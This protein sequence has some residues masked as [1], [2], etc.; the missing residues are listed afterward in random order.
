MKRI[1]FSLLLTGLLITSTSCANQNNIS[2][3]KELETVKGFLSDTQTELHEV[4]DIGPL[5]EITIKQGRQKAIIYVTKDGKYIVLGNIFDKDR[6][7]ITQERFAEISKVDFSAL[8]LQD[9]ITIT[10]GNG[11]KKIVMLTDVDCRFCRNAHAWL[12]NKDNYT[13]YVFL[14]P[15][16]IHPDAHAKSVQILCSDNPVE[17]LDIAKAGG[18]IKTGKCDTGENMLKKHIAIAAELGVEGTPFFITEDGNIING[19]NQPAL[20][21]YL[22]DKN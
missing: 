22:K 5:Y 3:V 8:P 7:N 15:L 18:E 10:K 9:A 6:K 13:L 11:A 12:K 14:F 21:S 17:A 2:K 4:R 19:F 16:G 1:L 20:E